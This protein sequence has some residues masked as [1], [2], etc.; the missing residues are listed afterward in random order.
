M[1]NDVEIINEVDAVKVKAD[2][3]KEGLDKGVKSERDRFKALNEAF[4]GDLKFAAEQF[5]AG[6][7]VEQAKID[8]GVILAQRVKEQDTQIAELQEKVKVQEVK[9][10][11]AVAPVVHNESATD[12]PDVQEFIAAARERS[13]SKG[14]SMGDAMK[15]LHREQDQK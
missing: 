6:A 2:A 3:H 4:P 1:S 8:Y 9:V 12:P 11:G 10:E 13:T 5:G 15:Q 14:I 7:T